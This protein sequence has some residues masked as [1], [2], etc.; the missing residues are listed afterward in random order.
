LLGL[1][2]RILGF[3]ISLDVIIIACLAKIQ[4]VKFLLP[5]NNNNVEDLIRS[6]L[7]TACPT[8]A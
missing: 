4:L 2:R 1:Y 5:S 7:V 8:L 3:E 6:N